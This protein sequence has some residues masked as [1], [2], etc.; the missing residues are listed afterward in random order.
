MRSPNRYIGV[1]IL[2]FLVLIYRLFN[3]QI[4]RHSEYEAIRFSQAYLKVEIPPE[5]GMVFDRNGEV[6][7]LSKLVES[8][9]VSPDKLKDRTDDI[10]RLCRV[11]GIDA[12]DT[13]KRIKESAENNRQFLWVKR[14]VDDDTARK[15]KEMKISGVGFKK[16]YKRFYPNGGLAG[17]LIGFRGVDEQPL[18]GVE[19]LCEDSLKGE[20]GYQYLQRDARQKHFTPPEA[21]GQPSKPGKNVYLTIDVVVQYTVENALEEVAKKYKPRWAGGMVLAP[22]TGEILAMANVPRFDPNQYQQYSDEVKRNRLVTDSYEPGSV[23]K[24]FVMSAV[25][26]QHLFRPDDRFFCENGSFKVGRRT[27]RDHK[28]LGWLTLSEVL[29]KSSNIGMSKV[30]LSLGKEN[31]YDCVKKFGFGEYSGIGLSGEHRGLITPRSRWNDYTV[32]S[33]SMGHEI[34][35]NSVQLTRAYASFANGGNLVKPQVIMKIAE[36][37]SAEKPADES[38]IKYF[39]TENTAHILSSDIEYQI[40]LMLREVVLSGTAASANLK[41]YAMAGKTGTAQKVNPDGTYSHD[42]Y[43]SSF[44]A[45][46][47]VDNPEI[48]VLVVVDEPKGGYYGSEVAAPY[49][50]KII[51]KTLKYFRVAPRENL[52][53]ISGIGH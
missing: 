53:R 43:L 4:S 25:L 20:P 12:N 7:A 8:V 39:R 41:S 11:L 17:Q 16:E 45:F 24:P 19:L 42:K 13:A 15:V 34:S 51:G 9:Y 31:I 49:V 23:F 30:G 40:R 27:I 5:K 32:A 50:A 3:I 48:L 14:R 21:V 28:P 47:P 35:V 29:S 18:G 38:G 26:E 10:K 2:A 22:K 46:A 52:S 1:V 37:P 33:V 36:R 44:I 6:L